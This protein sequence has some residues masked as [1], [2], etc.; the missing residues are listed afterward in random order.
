MWRLKVI[1]LHPV[2]ELEDEFYIDYDTDILAWRAHEFL[3][4]AHNVLSVSKP[5]KVL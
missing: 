1:Y 5:Y 4:K 2:V 3:F